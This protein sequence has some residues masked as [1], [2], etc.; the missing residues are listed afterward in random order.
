[1]DVDDLAGHLAEAPPGNKIG[2]IIAFP[3]QLVEGRKE[4]RHERNS[5]DCCSAV[6]SIDVPNSMAM[7]FVTIA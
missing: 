6:Y 7:S 5:R 2:H 4:S 1:M 3:W